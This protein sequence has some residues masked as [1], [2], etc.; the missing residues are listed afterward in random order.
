MYVYIWSFV[1]ILWSKQYI[2]EHFIN[3]HDV[4]LQRMS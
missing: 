4:I 1:V 3:N 2:R